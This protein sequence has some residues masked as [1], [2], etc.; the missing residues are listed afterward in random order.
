MIA[1]DNLLNRFQCAAIRNLCEGHVTR[2][3]IPSP[4]NGRGIIRPEVRDCWVARPDELLNVGSGLAKTALVWALHRASAAVCLPI[5]HFEP[6]E[7]LRF[8]QGGFY[9]WHGAEEREKDNPRRWAFVLYLT[10]NYTGGETE[11]RSG[12]LFKGRIGDLVAWEHDETRE[13]EVR[14]GT[15]AVLATWAHSAPFEEKRRAKLRAV[16]KKAETQH[17]NL[18][19]LKGL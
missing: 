14:E 4:K 11:F 8:D 5:T 18:E 13:R 9:Q 1:S 15:K 7:Y 6:W 10:D 3:E 12:A 2:A 19:D 17:L 16:L